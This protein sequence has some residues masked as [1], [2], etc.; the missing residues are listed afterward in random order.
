MLEHDPDRLA[1]L[2]D[3]PFLADVARRVG[4]GGTS[5][6]MPGHKHGA[7]A[8]GRLLGPVW[9]KDVLRADL[10]EMGGLDYLHAPAGALLEAQRRAAALFGA[11]ETFF[12]VNGTTGGNQAALF[13]ALTPGQK[14]LI[15]RASHRS[16]Y[17]A[18]VLTGAIPVYVPATA[19]PDLGA[20]V[21][22]DASRAAKVAAA[23]PDL[24]AVHVTSP[25][26]YGVA[27]DLSA[28]AGIAARAGAPLVVDEAH[29]T[30]F[31][32]HAAMPEPALRAG[33]DV[34]VQSAHKTLGSLTQSS[35][36]HVA[37]GRLD[38]RRLRDALAMLQSSSPSALLTASLDAARA[39][40]AVE[41][42]CSR[43]RWRWLRKRA[44][45][46]GTSPGC[47]ATALSS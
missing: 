22:V 37:G 10:S 44:R 20:P 35:F 34:A 8:A 17:A 14:V 24:A 45:R 39:V 6:H 36:L 5:F 33:A 30:H 9:G 26:Y 13:A 15:P 1:D 43:V 19:H 42:P 27:S 18:L 31:A 7:A 3:A 29:G 11:D 32:F 2:A 16:V 41:G 28:F 47:G 21:A 4:L 25:S 23:H 46:S 12:L 40:M 38:R